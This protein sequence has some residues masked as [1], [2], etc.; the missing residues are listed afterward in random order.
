MEQR[1]R[2][3]FFENDAQRWNGWPVKSRRMICAGSAYNK[4]S[5]SFARLRQTPFAERNPGEPTRGGRNGGNAADELAWQP[6][7]NPI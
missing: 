5:R 3:A 4:S 7:L 2:I 6:G 1:Y